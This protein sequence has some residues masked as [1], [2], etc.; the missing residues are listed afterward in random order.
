MGSLASTQ[1]FTQANPLVG[2][3]ASGDSIA[4]L[5]LGYL[6]S[7][8]NSFNNR[9]AWGNHY[10]VLF[11]QDDWRVSRKLTLNL[12]LRWDY[13]S[14]QTD[15]YN[16]IVA[17]FDTSAPSR[18]NGNGPPQDARPRPHQQTDQRRWVTVTARRLGRRASVRE[19]RS[20]CGLPVA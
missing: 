3:A 18:I 9:P 20:L 7:G 1:C 5:L 12:G 17:G 13:E 8:T 4:S 2:D 10:Y 11:L 19:Q 15:R 14:P 6:S 16:R